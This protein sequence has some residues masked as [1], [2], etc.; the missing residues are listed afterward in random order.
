[1]EIVSVEEGGGLLFWILWGRGW[2]SIVLDIVGEGIEVYCLGDGG[3]ERGWWYIVLEMVGVGG[4]GPLFLVFFRW[5]CGRHRGGR[6]EI[7][8]V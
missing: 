4:D 8:F 5:F 3:W 6:G 7:S 1:M 2:W